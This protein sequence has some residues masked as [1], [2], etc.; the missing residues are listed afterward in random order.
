MKIKLLN[1]EQ[2]SDSKSIQLVNGLNHTREH[3]ASRT[4]RC[5]F[6]NFMLIKAICNLF[7]TQRRALNMSAC[8]FLASG[9]CKVDASGTESCLKRAR[10]EQEQVNHLF[11][12][13]PWFPCCHGRGI[14][15]QYC[16][17]RPWRQHAANAPP[18]S[19]DHIRQLRLFC[20][21]GD[22]CHISGVG[23]SYRKKSKPQRPAAAMLG[24]NRRNRAGITCMWTIGD[25]TVPEGFSELQSI[26]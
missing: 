18:T 2:T 20:F 11:T 14:L 25:F 13:R 10:K 12:A 21:Q 6:R 16:A 8:L 26:R 19:A 1:A 9:L 23:G 3:T 7:S 17:Y 24:V 5:S 15:Q 22:G 4:G